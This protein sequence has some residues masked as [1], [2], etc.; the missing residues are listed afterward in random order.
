MTDKNEILIKLYSKIDEL[1]TLPAVV[2][3]I[4]RLLEDENSTVSDLSDTISRDPALSSN[5][6]KVANSA[7]YG[8]SREISGLEKAILLLGYKMVRSLA[9]SVGVVNTLAGKEKCRHFSREALWI[10]SLGSATVMD[11]LGK[12]FSNGNETGHL[13]VIGLLHDVGKI[14]L[15]LFFTEPFQEAMEEAQKEDR[16]EGLHSFEGRIIGIDH[17]EVGHV[18]LTRWKFPEI[19]CGPIGIHHSSEIPKGINA[20]VVAML[21]IAD[22]LSHESGLGGWE[23]PAPAESLKSE[24]AVLNISEKD[25]L[26][27]KGRLEDAKDGIQAFYSAMV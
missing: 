7:Y 15:D 16:G 27:L 8:F 25:L 18:L 11:E 9:L 20:S 19:I 4:L 10:H 6:L 5:I 2:P 26:D 1:P 17:S 24:L 12:R 14:V 13:F 3:K 21:K 23:L 22:A